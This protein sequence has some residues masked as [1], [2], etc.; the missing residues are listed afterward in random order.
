MPSAATPLLVWDGNKDFE[1]CVG[2]IP[3]THLAG[4]DAYEE[5]VR[6]LTYGHASG[7]TCFRI[8]ATYE[9]KLVARPGRQ[10]AVVIDRINLETL[11]PI[12]DDAPQEERKLSLVPNHAVRAVLCMVPALLSIVAC[13]Q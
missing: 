4:A 8:T 2:G 13:Y 12:L 1:L 10:P 11:E 6:E 5:I 3:A 9:V 7:A